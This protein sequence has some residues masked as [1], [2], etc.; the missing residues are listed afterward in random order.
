M[1]SLPNARHIAGSQADEV[2]RMAEYMEEEFKRYV[3][4]EETRY[5]VSEKMLETMA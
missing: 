3:S 5:S 1:N 4:G 2:H